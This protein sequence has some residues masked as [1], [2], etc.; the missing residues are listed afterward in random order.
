MSDPA[1]RH[2][3]HAGAF[4]ERARG[5]Q[6]WDVPSP[7]PGWTARDVV[8]HLIEWFPPFLAEGSGIQLPTGP[9]VDDDPVLAWQHH[10]DAVQAILDDDTTASTTFAHPH[11]PAR[12]LSEAIDSIYTSDVFMHTWD[13]ARATGQDDRLDPAECEGMLAG[14][15]EMDEMLRASGQYGPK[16]AVAA[17]ADPTARL[18][19]FIGRDPEWA[20]APGD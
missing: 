16:V 12:P 6:A 18:M 11:V 5:V 15:A 1:A 8:R 3:A 13:L 19:A 10:A 2:R 9:S 14:M 20:R 7:V 17:D 4:S